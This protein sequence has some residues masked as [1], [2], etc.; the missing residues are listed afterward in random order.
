MIGEVT[1]AIGV[2]RPVEGLHDEVG[3][4]FAAEDLDGIK[5]GFRCDPRADIHRVEGRAGIPGASVRRA[6]GGD[7]IAA[8]GAGHVRAVPTAV[9][10]V[11]VRRGNGLVR[12]RGVIG[13]AREVVSAGHLGRIGV[14]GR[15]ASLL[16]LER[17][18]VGRDRA[19]PAEVRVRV[20]D[21][22]IDDADGDALAGEA[23]VDP[24]GGRLDERD[25]DEVVTALG[26]EAMHGLDARQCGDRL[27]A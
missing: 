17:R 12:V 14:G 26:H 25:R 8:R 4:A 21:A 5:L 20:V 22:G 15:A 19:R 10:G 16:G 1:V 2:Q 23:R 24:R 18:L 9:E 7:A 6:V 13:I 3:R 27:Q 11:V